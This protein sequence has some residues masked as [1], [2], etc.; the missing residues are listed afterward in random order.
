MHSTLRTLLRLGS[1]AFLGLTGEV[2][3]TA[4]RNVPRFAGVDASGSFGP[5]GLPPLH[6][7]VLGDSSCTGPGLDDPDEIWLRRIGRNFADRHEVTVDSVAVGG[8]R[9]DDVLRDQVPSILPTRPD[10]ALVSVGSNDML[11][12]VPLRTFERNL[13]T[14]VTELLSCT[15]TVLLSGVGDLGTIPR[16]PFF[17]SRIMRRRGLHADQAHTAV[18]ARH[19]QVTKIPIRERCGSAFDDPALYSPDLLHVNGEGHRLWAEAAIPSIESALR[20]APAGL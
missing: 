18:A 11:Y 3:S 16:L 5:A 1:A 12:G 15:S 17:L 8:S 4:Y 7:A 10:L 6:I 19:P 2:L 14:I 9:A 13:E 20:A